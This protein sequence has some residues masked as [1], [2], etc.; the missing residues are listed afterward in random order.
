MRPFSL[1]AHSCSA[2]SSQPVV[3]AKRCLRARLNTNQCQRCI[4]CCPGNALS[5]IHG[6]I[7]LDSDQCTGC[8]SC[9]AAC[10]QDALVSD[11]NIDSLLSS[12][13]A[14]ANVIVSCIHQ[15]QHHPDEILVPCVG[16][17]SKQVL[18][19]ILLSNCKSVTFNLAGCTE[20][21]NKLVSHRF[22]VDCQ[23]MNEELSE[24]N[25]THVIVVEK[26]EHLSTLKTDRRS[27]LTKMLDIVVDVS[28]Q[29]RTSKQEIFLPEPGNTRRLPFKAQLVRKMLA[30]L[31]VES[32]GK[33]LGLFGH[34]LSV[35]EHCD[36]C[37]LCKGICPTGAISIDR[38]NQGKRLRF[39]MLDC[40]G[41]GL[42]VEF[43]KKHALS[44]KRC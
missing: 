43:C 40:S 28:S 21:C 4:E 35:S 19:A 36:C 23:Q 16:I 25:S 1:F 41:C 38:S 39:E 20:C 18:S 31:D 22:L 6:R 33:I 13:R 14:E 3:Y 7:C 44:L 17:L 30:G 15:P 5:V 32:Q 29:G 42:C 37:P 10:P 9:V 11:C 34:N 26:S 12:F 2:S 27:Y 24:L 8:M